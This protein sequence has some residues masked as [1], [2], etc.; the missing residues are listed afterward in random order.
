MVTRVRGIRAATIWR[1]CQSDLLS[2]KKVRHRPRAELV[3]QASPRCSLPERGGRG[4]R[5]VPT[6]PLVADL[7]R[8]PPLVRY[9]LPMNVEGAADAGELWCVGVGPKTTGPRVHEMTLIRSIPRVEYD[10]AED[11]LDLIHGL[12]DHGAMTAVETAAQEFNKAVVAQL[13]ALVTDDD[14]GVSLYPETV[15]AFEAFLTAFRTFSDRTEVW[16]SARYGKSS[17][18]MAAFR[19]ALHHEYDQNAAYRFLYE[20]R[21]MATH[22]SAV[23]NKSQI[24]KSARRGGGQI[25]EWSMAIDGPALVASIGHKMKREVREELEAAPAPLHLVVAVSKVHQ[26]CLRAHCKLVLAIEPEF[27][28]AVTRL[29]A[30]NAEAVTG[31]HRSALPHKTSPHGMISPR[32]TDTKDDAAFDLSIRPILPLDPVELLALPAKCTRILAKGSEPVTF[33]SL[34]RDPG[35]KMEVDASGQVVGL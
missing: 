16:I 33:E 22:V 28:E 2:R 10:A 7:R 23:V 1:D 14:S 31:V 19:A 30:L 12:N 25:V 27:T 9:V 24:K 4:T 11:A 17:S 26:S 8:L 35:M 15:R 18:H 20:M 34:G 29:T 3:A 6:G 5:S 13:A 21:N 32:K